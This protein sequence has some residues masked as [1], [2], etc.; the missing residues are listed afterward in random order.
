MSTYWLLKKKSSNCCKKKDKVSIDRLW[1]GNVVQTAQ[2]CPWGRPENHI[3][4][5]D[6]ETQETEK[7]RLEPEEGTVSLNPFSFKIIRFIRNP[8]QCHWEAI[9][10]ENWMFKSI[11]SKQNT[12]F[13]TTLC[14]SKAVFRV[15]HLFFHLA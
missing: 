7:L 12:T 8:S 11:P 5:L 13:N 2:T 6:K 10:P 14:T 9:Q 4:A 15:S 1:Q 3:K